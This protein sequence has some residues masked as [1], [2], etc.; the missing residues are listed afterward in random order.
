MNST[1]EGFKWS[2]DCSFV[3]SVR[4]INVS[5]YFNTSLFFINERH[6]TRRVCWWICLPSWEFSSYMQIHMIF[7][8][9][10]MYYS[11]LFTSLYCNNAHLMHT[12]QAFLKFHPFFIFFLHEWRREKNELKWRITTRYFLSW[13]SSSFTFSSKYVIQNLE[14]VNIL[15]QWHEYT[16]D[17]RLALLI[18]DYCRTLNNSILWSKNSF[19]LQLTCT[20]KEL[21]TLRDINLD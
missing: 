19:N 15:C 16:W 3:V 21:K 18:T 6:T 17:L 12:M 8:T 11:A 20:L 2:P 10:L 1:L 7:N 5:A 14:Y 4:K 9:P 13:A